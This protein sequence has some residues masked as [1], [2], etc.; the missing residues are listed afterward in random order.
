MRH[1]PARHGREVRLTERPVT[2]P[3]PRFVYRDCEP[4][5]GEVLLGLAWCGVALDCSLSVLLGL[6]AAAKE[7]PSLGRPWSWACTLPALAV[8]LLI[9]VV[10][11]LARRDLARMRLGLV[12]P[13]GR[14]AT[15]SA[16]D[17]CTGGL[18]GAVLAFAGSVVVLII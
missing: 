15:T 3:A 10:R 17:C 2:Q 1:D 4:H 18:V 16:A 12:D 13:R 5:R 8:L 11:T 6:L 7:L 9:L 14:V